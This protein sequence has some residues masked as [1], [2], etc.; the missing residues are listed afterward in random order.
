MKPGETMQCEHC[1]ATGIFRLHR[2]I[3]ARK[4]RE[5]S[6][7]NIHKCDDCAWLVCD[8]CGSFHGKYFACYQDRPR[9]VKSATAHLRAVL[10]N[11][12]GTIGRGT[13]GRRE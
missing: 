13:T 2:R 10:E 9:E 8:N 4:K 11:G 1:G 12:G 7:P 5:G 6:W 3:S